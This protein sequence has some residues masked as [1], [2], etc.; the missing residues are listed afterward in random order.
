MAGGVVAD[1]DGRQLRRSV[2]LGQPLLDLLLELRSD[3]A[4]DGNSAYQLRH[5]VRFGIPAAITEKLISVHV[6]SPSHSR[7]SQRH[8]LCSGGGASLTILYLPLLYMASGSISKFPFVKLLS[9]EAL[10]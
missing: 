7:T 8:L 5:L 4:G 10:N 2:P 1:Q 3:L 9:A 6:H